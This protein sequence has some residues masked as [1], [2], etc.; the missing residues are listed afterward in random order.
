MVGSTESVVWNYSRL[1][2]R[3]DPGLLYRQKMDEVD[4]VLAESLEH[5]L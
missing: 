4:D 5:R 2:L 3:H 1:D